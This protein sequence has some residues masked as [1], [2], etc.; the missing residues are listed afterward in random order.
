[1]DSILNPRKKWVEKIQVNVQIKIQGGHLKLHIDSN[2]CS[3]SSI[4][5]LRQ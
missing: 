2:Q 4:G 5:P 1:M 3:G